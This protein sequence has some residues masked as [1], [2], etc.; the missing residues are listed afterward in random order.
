MASASLF[1]FTVFLF[2]ALVLFSPNEKNVA[3]AKLCG[4]LS[5]TFSGVC[6]QDCACDAKCLR[7]G[8]VSGSCHVHNIG[9]ACFCYRKC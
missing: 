1:K 9:R 7:E 2:I 3:E 5:S 8:A 6:L 4:K